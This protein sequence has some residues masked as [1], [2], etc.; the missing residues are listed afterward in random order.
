MD[1]D[2]YMAGIRDGIEGGR[3]IFKND[4]G[5]DPSGHLPPGLL[6]QKN[7]RPLNA[8][9]R[10][11]I[12]SSPHQE[13]FRFL[14]FGAGAGVAALE[15]K[16]CY[17]GAQV[18]TVGKQPFHPSYALQVSAMDMS[19]A[20]RARATALTGMPRDSLWIMDQLLGAQ[21]DRLDLH[22]ALAAQEQGEQFFF[23]QRQIDKQ[24]VGCFPFTFDEP[25][26]SF[27]IIHDGFGVLRYTPGRETIEALLE[28][29][30]PAGTL[31]IQD[32]ESWRYHDYRP[33]S[34]TQVGDA[35]IVTGNDDV[36]NHLLALQTGLL[37]PEHQV[38]QLR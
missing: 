29:L 5:Y 10:A 6:E 35:L 31:I 34:A 11:A 14:E 27:D 1:Y 16:R 30:H 19:D 37:Q 32:A 33:R 2:A 36:T 15:V 28:Y 13:G 18:T 21:M 25:T 7:T 24:Y 4:P 9:T 22:I 26:R 8:L 3:I 38:P 17:E 20:I 12:A 23:W